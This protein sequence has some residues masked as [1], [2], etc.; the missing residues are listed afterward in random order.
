MTLCLHILLWDRAWGARTWGES[1]SAGPLQPETVSSQGGTIAGVEIR[2]MWGEAEQNQNSSLFR[3]GASRGRWYLYC[4]S[5]QRLSFSLRVHSWRALRLN[6]NLLKGKSK[7][8]RKSKQEIIQNRGMA[9]VGRSIQMQSHSL[10]ITWGLASCSYRGPPQLSSPSSQ[11]PV[12]L[13]C[14]AATAEILLDNFN[15]RARMGLISEAHLFCSDKDNF[16]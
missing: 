1:V 8:T 6:E 3:N 4:A 10:K 5:V 2:E 11:S 9:A 14:A 15:S 12:F 13:S 7:P 16:L